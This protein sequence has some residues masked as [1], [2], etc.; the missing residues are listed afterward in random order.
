MDRRLRKDDKRLVA[1][2]TKP[3]VQGSDNAMRM[4]DVMWNLEQSTDGVNDVY[5]LLEAGGDADALNDDVGSGVINVLLVDGAALQVTKAARHSDGRVEVDAAPVGAT[6]VFGSD[7]V[8]RPSIFLD[9]NLQ[10]EPVRRAHFM[11]VRR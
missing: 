3:H 9:T 7:T 10:S 1:D 8:E 4:Y 2:L 11:G 5:L 6:M